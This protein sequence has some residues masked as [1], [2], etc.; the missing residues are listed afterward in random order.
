MYI[1]VWFV[2]TNLS[3]E[4]NS[5]I[6]IAVPIPEDQAASGAEIELAIKQALQEA[7]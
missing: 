2:D 1:L 5:G 6:V 7:K 4:S 3:L